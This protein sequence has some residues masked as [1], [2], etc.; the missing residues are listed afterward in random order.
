MSY[1]SCK[2]NEIG[3]KRH[4]VQQKLTAT[5]HLAA[6]IKRNLAEFMPAWSD[7]RVQKQHKQW[8]HCWQHI[9]YMSTVCRSVAAAVTSEDKWSWVIWAVNWGN[10]DGS[11][12]WMLDGGNMFGII[13]RNTN[14]T[15]RL[16]ELIWA[17]CCAPSKLFSGIWW[18][19]GSFKIIDVCT[20]NWFP[21]ISYWQLTAT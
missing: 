20:N 15:S 17:K 8:L 5:R 13:Y 1:K 12:G 10:N 19:S 18:H 11:T 2:T 21:M 7:S 9:S 6:N 4:I 16:V 14:T 3:N